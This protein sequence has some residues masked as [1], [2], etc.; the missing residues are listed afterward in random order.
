VVVEAGTGLEALERLGEGGPF[1]LALVDWNMPEMDGLAFVKAV[2]GQPALSGLRLVMV[3][4]ESEEFRVRHALEAGADE[5]IMKPFSREIVLEKLQM[6]G[7]TG[8]TL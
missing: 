4:S 5:Y 2:R 1:D 3:T 8:E 6:L 7:M